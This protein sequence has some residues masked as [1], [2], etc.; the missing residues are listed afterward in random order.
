MVQV[1]VALAPLQRGHGVHP[2]MISVGTQGVNG[3]PEA[4]LNLEAP[5]VE[6]DDVQWAHAQVGTEQDQAPAA[7]VDDPDEANRQPQ[8]TPK[9]IAAVVA[10][11]DLALVVERA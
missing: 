4:R 6:A 11:G 8:G 7:G 9:Q 2:K 3:L 1:L 5:G 10:Q